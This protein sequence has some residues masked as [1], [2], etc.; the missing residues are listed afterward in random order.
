M[1][2]GR[3]EDARS[4]VFYILGHIQRGILRK[5]GIHT[6]NIWIFIYW[7][8]V[9]GRGLKKNDFGSYFPISSEIGVII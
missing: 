5:Y 2:R 3:G 1:G 6:K 8:D 9:F 7:K 4:M